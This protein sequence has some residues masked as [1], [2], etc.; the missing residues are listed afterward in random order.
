MT[1][2]SDSLEPA[3]L[4]PAAHLKKRPSQP[5]PTATTAPI[6]TSAL[7][8][9]SSIPA[10]P[11]KSKTKTGTPTSTAKTPKPKQPT[12][13]GTPNP[14]VLKKPPTPYLLFSVDHR[15]AHPELKGANVAKECS[16]AWKL[17]SEA[18][19]K[20]YKEKHDALQ[21]A[22]LAQM[23]ASSQLNVLAP[24][25]DSAPSEV[26][27]ETVEVTETQNISVDVVD[28]VVQSAAESIQEAPAESNPTP[29]EPEP[30]CKTLSERETTPTPESTA[31]ANASL[32]R[33][34]IDAPETT[35][36]PTPAVPP[37]KS[38]KLATTSSPS[39]SVPTKE[40]VEEKKPP[41]VPA[42]EW[43]RKA[44]GFK[45]PASVASAKKK[46]AVAQVSTPAKKSVSVPL[47]REPSQVDICSVTDG[48]AASE[49]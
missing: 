31:D 5:Q 22:Y 47:E 21:A 46:A 36:P 2:E 25:A 33:S 8:P 48:P 28:E 1:T 37:K 15:A 49:S 7:I 19:K 32:K 17:V 13:R 34:L 29:Q 16:N 30:E 41:K 3:V 9:T 39:A 12:K 43:K 35:D 45:N 20:V 40:S 23:E 18:D 27:N 26:V 10:T 42:A 14:D 4:L 6:P 38:P 44:A 11:T 24:A